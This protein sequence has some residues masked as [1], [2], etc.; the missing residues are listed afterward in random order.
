MLEFGV[1]DVLQGGGVA[2]QYH[3]VLAALVVLRLAKHTFREYSVGMHRVI[4]A[5][6]TAVLVVACGSAKSSE[7][8]RTTGSGNDEPLFA[9]A[10]SPGLDS[11]ASQ[12]EPD[13]V[14]FM[15]DSDVT[16][17]QGSIH[18]GGLDATLPGEAPD[19]APSIEIDGGLDNGPAENDAS[20]EPQCGENGPDL[21]HNGIEDACEACPAS[22][23]RPVWSWGY[24]RTP[25]PLGAN[26]T[27][28]R[29]DTQAVLTTFQINLDVSAGPRSDIYQ[30]EEILN[31]LW[32]SEVPEGRLIELETI[33]V[34][35]FLGGGYDEILDNGG[36]SIPH[37]YFKV[38]VSPV[39]DEDVVII[40]LR[41]HGDCHASEEDEQPV[42]RDDAE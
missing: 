31:A 33:G 40:R 3:S 34:V 14:D 38:T 27:I 2:H 24:M 1:L 6:A 35:G 17:D 10:M 22:G 9:D 28:K 32:D 7:V 42:C 12:G 37:N 18:D 20:T 25:T 13:L 23:C 4:L 21:D 41:L 11:G 8:S 19:A 26:V 29:A 30:T 36:A 39:P 5:M 16:P 15:G